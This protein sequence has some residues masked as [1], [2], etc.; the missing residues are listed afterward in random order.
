[1]DHVELAVVQI[2]GQ[3]VVRVVPGAAEL[4][5]VGRLRER[6]DDASGAA[7]PAA[8]NSVTSWPTAASPS[9]RSETT[10]SIPP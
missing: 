2:R 3:R 5:R 9:V 6:R 10:S 8:P 7:R 4:A 1:V